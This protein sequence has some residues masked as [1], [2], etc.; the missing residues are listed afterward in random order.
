MI[1][2]TEVLE[3]IFKASVMVH[4]FRVLGANGQEATLEVEM[5]IFG[6]PPSK[7]FLQIRCREPQP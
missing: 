1:N 5:E 6:E 4:S 2:L 3:R 7:T